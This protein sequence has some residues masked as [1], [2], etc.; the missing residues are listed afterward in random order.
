MNRDEYSGFRDLVSVI[1]VC[2][3]VLLAALTAPLWSGPAQNLLGSLKDWLPM[4][5]SSEQ[6]GKMPQ[7]PTATW[8]DKEIEAA[9]MQC[10]QALAPVTAD[11]APLDP[12]RDGNCGAPAPV[13]VKSIGGADKVSFD[14]PLVLDCA[15]VVGL[16]RWLKDR[17]QPAAREVFSSPVSKIIGSSY[18]CRNVYNLP[19]GHLSQHAFANAID[20][21]M[22]VL[23]D[24]RKVDVTHGWGPTQRDLVAA[25]KAEKAGPGITS[26]L[27]Q[28][29][30]NAKGAATEVVKV[31]T[32]PALNSAAVASPSPAS[33]DDSEVAAKF[34]RLA[35]DGGCKIFSTVLGPEANDAHR[36]HLH[37]DLQERKTSVCE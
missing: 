11:V 23:A 35:H 26:S 37:L 7:G 6:E 18:A 19:D 20:L 1:A 17:V 24:G 25:A 14:P 15:M 36:T 16:D 28:Q 12:I 32:S 10:I 34:L 31:S 2:G 27:A 29:K 8:T 4:A 30:T 21:P 9:L 3:F 13:L 5:P 22:F 33:A